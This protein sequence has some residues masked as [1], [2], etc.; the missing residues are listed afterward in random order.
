MKI[1]H[2]ISSE[3][4][5]VIATR[6]DLRWAL[7]MCTQPVQLWPPLP[8]SLF[9][10]F[11]SLRISHRLPVIRWDQPILFEKHWSHFSLVEIILILAIILLL[12][13]YQVAS[14]NVKKFTK[15]FTRNVYKK[16]SPGRVHQEE[17]RRKNSPEMRLQRTHRDSNI[18]VMFR[19]LVWIAI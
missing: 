19:S 12:L 8:A 3:T 6:H 4:R 5:R 18:R 14:A 13:Q 1:V 7:R 11:L 17:S 10:S 2:R 15:E 9:Q 16:S